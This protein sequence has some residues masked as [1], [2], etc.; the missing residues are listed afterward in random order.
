MGP[1]DT[2]GCRNWVPEEGRPCPI[3]PRVLGTRKGTL[4]TAGPG[5]IPGAADIHKGPWGSVWPAGIVIKGPVAEEACRGGRAVL[6]SQAV[7]YSSFLSSLQPWKAALPQIV[8]SDHWV[9][10]TLP[11]GLTG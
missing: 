3:L 4:T 2:L 7:T 10:N 11:T 5:Q 6:E 9:V 8:L 1:E